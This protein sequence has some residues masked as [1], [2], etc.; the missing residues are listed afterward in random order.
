MGAA[1]E[2]LKEKYR[3]TDKT[4]V[5]VA[6]GGILKLAIFYLLDMS[7]RFYRCMELDNTSLTILDVEEDRSILRVLNDAHHLESGL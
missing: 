3:H 7:S 5:V 2:E 1:L 4:I 6:H